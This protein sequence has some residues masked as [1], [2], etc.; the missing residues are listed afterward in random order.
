[1]FILL[2]SLVYGINNLNKFAFDANE[3]N[4]KMNVLHD[5]P[6]SRDY[7]YNFQ[8][9]KVFTLTKQDWSSF[10]TDILDQGQ[11]NGCTTNAISKALQIQ[12]NFYNWTKNIEQTTPVPSF[13][14][15]ICTDEFADK[16]CSNISN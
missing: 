5:E 1:M 11:I 4:Y 13:R 3:Y 10:V 6:D 15:N 14:K 7:I 12:E 8:I 9:P 2:F 16:L